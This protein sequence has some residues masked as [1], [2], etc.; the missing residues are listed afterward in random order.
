MNQ[1]QWN[2]ICEV[3]ASLNQDQNQFVH[4]KDYFSSIQ[5]NPLI[6]KFYTTVELVQQ[7]VELSK[8]QAIFCL[9]FYSYSNHCK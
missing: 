9:W 8:A 6:A 2:T 5:T 1:S 3:V 7:N 4:L